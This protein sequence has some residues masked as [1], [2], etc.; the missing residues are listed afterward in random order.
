MPLCKYKYSCIIDTPYALFE[1]LLMCKDGDWNRTVFFV[2]DGIADEYLAHLSK[3]VYF[4]TY[5]SEYHTKKQK[6]RMKLRALVYRILYIDHTKLFAQDH[7]EASAQLIGRNKY[8]QIEDSP[9]FYSYPQ[10]EVSPIP[11]RLRRKL[12]RLIFWGPIHGQTFGRNKYCVDRWVTEETDLQSPLLQGKHYTL[13]NLKQL[14]DSASLEKKQYI[15]NVFGIK[16]S[17]IQT[18]RQY[19]TILFTQPFEE[20]GLTI[21]DIAPIYKPVIERYMVDGI[22]IKPHPRD[23][24]EWSMIFPDVPIIHTSVPMQILNILGLEFKRAITC[25]S[26]AISAMS[27][28]TEIIWLGIP[29][30]SKLMD[31]YGKEMQC[32]FVKKFKNIIHA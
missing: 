11:T 15:Y 32:P 1:Y 21:E 5:E 19:K 22:V 20:E 16:E 18:I 10:P 30:P 27:N 31:V 26:S 8:T 25:F 9:G 23:H 7:L 13:F 3:I 17:L 2:G 4:P 24:M 28:D 12:R 14:W 29:N 6:I